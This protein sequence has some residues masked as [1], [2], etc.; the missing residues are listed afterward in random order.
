MGIVMAAIIMN[1]A[2]MM[3]GIVVCQKQKSIVTIAKE[4]NVLATRQMS[5]S[6]HFPLIKVFYQFNHTVK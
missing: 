3:V 6:A 5:I 4:L 2:S 1:H